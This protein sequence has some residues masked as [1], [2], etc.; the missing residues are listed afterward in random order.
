MALN[1]IQ[2]RNAKLPEKP[3]K[4]S[5]SGGLY[6]VVTPTGSKLW[7]MDCRYRSKRL[8]LSFG[9]WPAVSLA[10][11][12]GLRDAAKALIEE[13][14]DPR[15]VVPGKKAVDAPDSLIVATRETFKAVADRWIDNNSAE[16]STGHFTRTMAGL[17]ND[18]FPA[19]G[20]R[21]IAEIEPLEILSAVR[22]VE[23]RGVRDG[24]HRLRATASKIFRFAI[25]E[26][27]AKRDP[28]ADIVDAL[29][30]KP[31][32][33][34]RAKFSESELPIL[35]GKL[36]NEPIEQITRD[37]LWLTLLTAV[38]TNETRFADIAEFSGLDSKEPLRRIPAERMKMNRD[39]LVP[40]PRQAVAIVKRRIA[41]GDGTGLLFSKRGTR[42]GSLSE[43]GML[44]ALYRMG[45]HSRVTVH[46]FRGAFST[47]ANERGWN[48]D[49]IEVQLAH[50]EGSVRGAYNAAEYLP[51]RRELLQ[52]WA[53]LVIGE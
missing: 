47:I 25:A 36:L 6:L 43:N 38:R 40:L 50:V 35:R 12:R 15:A 37:A 26:G 14:S 41:E 10:M 31:R 23:E 29:A 20:D 42:S 18:L 52:W 22:A 39:H 45:Y 5:D 27:L 16:W 1:D 11:A 7:R 4:I 21:H 48:R 32:V 9:Q 34:H 2:I 17:R 46:G 28:A 30:R 53:D 33:K 8:T 24:A 19:I 49:W 3:R 51:G 13:G 44:Y